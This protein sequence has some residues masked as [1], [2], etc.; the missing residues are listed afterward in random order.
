[1]ATNIA[2]EPVPEESSSFLTGKEKYGLDD[3]DDTHRNRTRRWVPSTR[4]VLF[5]TL[6]TLTAN[7]IVMLF[8]AFKS[9]SSTEHCKGPETFHGPLGK[10]LG[11]QSVAHEYDSYWED[12]QGVSGVIKMPHPDFDGEML[13]ASISM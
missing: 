13:P 8:V 5:L 1:M 2:Y 10:S 11:W 12:I 4:T 7:I 3:D 9:Q 6:L